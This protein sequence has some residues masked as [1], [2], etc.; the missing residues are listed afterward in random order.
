MRPRPPQGQGWRKGGD[1]F[2]EKTIFL[3]YK[4]QLMILVM[5]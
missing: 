3:G 4:N 1:H 2:Y 5:L